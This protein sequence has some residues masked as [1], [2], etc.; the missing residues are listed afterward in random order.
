LEIE[1][2]LKIVYL[3]IQFV[4]YFVLQT[5]TRVLT[6]CC[7]L[8]YLSMR[9]NAAISRAFFRAAVF[10]FITPRFAALSIAL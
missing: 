9:R 5:L 6:A 1:I 2:Y 7:L 10:F 3:E 8:L 4:S